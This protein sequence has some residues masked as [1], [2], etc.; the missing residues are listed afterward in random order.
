MIVFNITRE[1]DKLNTAKRTIKSLTIG[2][3]V[4]FF[5]CLAEKIGKD[6]FQI[7]IGHKPTM[8]VKTDFIIQY[9]EKYF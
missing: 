4:H 1:T 2:D 3:E 8:I 9:I 5:N 7:K 6:K